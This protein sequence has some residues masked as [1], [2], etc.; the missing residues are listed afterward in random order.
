VRSWVIKLGAFEVGFGVKD[1]VVCIDGKILGKSDGL[2]V[3]SMVGLTLGVEF[4]PCD[5]IFDGSTDGM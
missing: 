4:G 5:G 2:L 3:A 1:S